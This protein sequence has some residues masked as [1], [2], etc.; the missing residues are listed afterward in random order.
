MHAKEPI[1]SQWK[2]IVI[3]MKCMLCTLSLPLSNVTGRDTG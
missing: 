3:S 2:G 1:C